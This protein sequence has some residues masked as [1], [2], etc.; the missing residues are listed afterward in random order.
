MKTI[1]LHIGTP[2]TGTTY[3]QEFLRKN[4]KLL[5]EK[6]ILYPIEKDKKYVYSRSHVS[7]SWQHVPLIPSI[8]GVRVNWLTSEETYLDG[9]ALDEL[10]RDIENAKED[11]I[12]LSSEVF[13]DV[14]TN[15][16][17]IRNLKNVF[18]DFNVKIIIYLR[19]QDQYLLSYFQEGCK[20]GTFTSFDLENILMLF[21][22]SLCYYDR[23]SKWGDVFGDSNIIVR[24]FEK[25]Q[26]RENSLS[27]DF[28]SIIGINDYSNFEEIP[29]INESLTLEK[30]I[31][32][33]NMNKYLIGVL[34]NDDDLKKIIHQKVRERVIRNKSILQKGNIDQLLS[35]EERKKIL[36]L[37]SNQNEN[38]VKRFLKGKTNKL[39]M[40]EPATTA[41]DSK[42][43]DL[44]LDENTRFKAYAFLLEEIVRDLKL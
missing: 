40:E 15:K 29:V 5:K 27:K 14:F 2:K 21:H 19:R 33:M 44:T 11:K 6:G 8:T 23:L 17:L 22:S 36:D 18:R 30:V 32:L 43:H 20:G 24:P 12:L 34:E 3:L 1:Y 35:H 38:V 10:L 7:L 42:L 39:F 13:Y 25:N 28:L 4:N 41:L 16:A 37:Y 9:E 31:F 26:L